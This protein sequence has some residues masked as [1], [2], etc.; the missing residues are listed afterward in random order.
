[1]R[2]LKIVNASWYL[3]SCKW[4]HLHRIS[5]RNALHSSFLC[6]LLLHLHLGHDK[7]IHHLI[8][9]TRLTHIL[10]LLDAASIILLFLDLSRHYLLKFG[11]RHLSSLNSF[12]IP[13]NILHGQ[14]LLMV[15]T[16]ILIFVFVL[17]VIR[18]HLLVWI[19]CLFSSFELG[20]LMLILTELH[21]Q[22]DNHVF[23]HLMPAVF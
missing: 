21:L 14:L 6:S 16:S 1:L 19:C 18:L 3:N 7:L 8:M 15:A 12:L 2:C 13:L 17:I 5:S 9:R 23:E 10:I 4:T 22:F 20:V 11:L